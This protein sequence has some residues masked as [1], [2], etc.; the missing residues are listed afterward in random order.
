MALSYSRDPFCAST[1]TY[2]LCKC[3]LTSRSSARGIRFRRLAAWPHCDDHR[4]GGV[5]GFA[6]R[7]AG[8]AGEG[9]ADDPALGDGQPS[10]VAAL[11]GDRQG[12]G[13]VL[14]VEGVGGRLHGGAA[15]VD[16]GH[17]SRKR[18]STVSTR[19][20]ITPSGDGL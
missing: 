4:Y 18:A 8:A 20:A 5:P 9:V 2:R 1:S 16:G 10:S 12:D 15:P 14:L 11:V 13:H 6:G 17:Q 7:A 19:A 3:G